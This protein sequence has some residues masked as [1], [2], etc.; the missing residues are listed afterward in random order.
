MQLDV[1]CCSAGHTRGLVSIITLTLLVDGYVLLESVDTSKGL[2][3]RGDRK[4]F[5]LMIHK[6]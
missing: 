4:G 5:K 1:F 2:G 6:V 3:K